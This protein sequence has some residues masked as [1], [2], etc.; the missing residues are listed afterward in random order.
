MLKPVFK[1]KAAKLGYLFNRA[2][3]AGGGVTAVINCTDTSSRLALDIMGRTLLETDLSY[4][5]HAGFKRDGN[6]VKGLERYSFFN[7]HNAV[8]RPDKIGKVFTFLYCFFHV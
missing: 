7:A 8:F 4:L 1:E 3:T 2:I 5:K 6:P